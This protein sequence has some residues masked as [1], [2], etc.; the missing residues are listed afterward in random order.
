M[1]KKILGLAYWRAH[2]LKC[3]SEFSSPHSRFTARRAV[4]SLGGGETLASLAVCGCWGRKGG[5]LGAKKGQKAVFT[6]GELAVL[7]RWSVFALPNQPINAH[8]QRSELLAFR[9]VGNFGAHFARKKPENPLHKGN[10]RCAIG[11]LR[12][13]RGTWSAFRGRLERWGTRCPLCQIRLLRPFKPNAHFVG[14]GETQS[15]VLLRFVYI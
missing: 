8:L 4:A 12:A 15:G 3:Q 5:E 10:F 13:F 14:V 2:S 11:K 1:G 6:L 7:R 9:A